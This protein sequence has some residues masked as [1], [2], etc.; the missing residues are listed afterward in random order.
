MTLVACGVCH[1]AQRSLASKY[2]ISVIWLS[3]PC[4]SFHHLP[5]MLVFLFVET[6]LFYKHTSHTELWYTPVTSFEPCVLIRDL[7]DENSRT[8][9][10]RVSFR[11]T[12]AIDVLV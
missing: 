7:M 9:S 10:R 4:V 8:F 1:N 12:G 5:S 11:D 3:F 6:S 2:I